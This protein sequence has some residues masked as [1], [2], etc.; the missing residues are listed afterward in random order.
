MSDDLSAILDGEP[1]RL[2]T[3]FVFVEGPVWHPDGFLYFSD[4]RRSQTLRWVPGKGVEIVRND[5]NQ[6]NGLTLDLS[7]RLITCEGAAR[8]VTLTEADGTVTILAEEWKGKQLNWPNDV[9]GHSNGSLYF[10][11]P[12]PKD[13]LLP[14]QLE[15]GFGG[16]FRIDSNGNIHLATDECEYPNGLAFSPDESI[17]YVA[18][19]FLDDGCRREA[20]RN[21]I[22][23]HRRIRAFDVKPDGTLSNNRIFADM[24]SAEIGVPDGMKVDVQGRVFC[25]GNGGTCIFDDAGRHL[26]TIRTPEV[27]ANC[28]FGGP[29]QRTLF[30]TARTSLYIVQVKEPGIKVP[31]A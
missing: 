29:D 4:I 30:L 14:E 15:I 3:G 17:L 20:E 22:C 18:I 21:E 24:S 9:I 13:R 10:T 19:S 5:T 2:A 8:C 11:D 26:G 23:T 1:I 16:V 25:T 12:E 31:R 7:G 27:P 28:A 6:G